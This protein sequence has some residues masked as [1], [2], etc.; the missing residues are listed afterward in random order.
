[1]AKSLRF[2][3]IFNHPYL[4]EM[5]FVP[6]S[7][8]WGQINYASVLLNIE[9]KKAYIR[10]SMTWYHW[11]HFYYYREDVRFHAHGV[12]GE[13]VEDQIT[14]IHRQ[15]ILYRMKLGIQIMLSSFALIAAGVYLIIEYSSTL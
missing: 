8:L 3:F 12:E 6:H 2:E 4:V 7:H 5:S 10:S 11:V 14:L 13:V 1:M 9:E 15:D